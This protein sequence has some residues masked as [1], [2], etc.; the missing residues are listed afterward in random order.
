[1]LKNTTCNAPSDGNSDKQLIEQLMKQN[2][3]LTKELAKSKQEIAT[4][5]ESHN[6]SESLSDQQCQILDKEMTF[7]REMYC[8][9]FEDNF[10]QSA[11]HSMVIMPNFFDEIAL[12]VKNKCPLLTSIIS[13][14]AIGKSTERNTGKKDSNFK[15]KAALQAI[16]SLDDVKSERTKSSFSILF[17]LL[18]F[19]NGAGK[20]MF[21]VLEP[22]G[23]CKSYQF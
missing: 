1:M 6:I 13:T 16:L 7:L 23:L 11:D 5:T 3:L 20:A 19:A 9:D 21:T 2:Q 8:I 22:F 10:V 4:L 12:N 17:G 18:L 14:L 15:F